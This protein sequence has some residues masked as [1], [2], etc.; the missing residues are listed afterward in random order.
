LKKHLATEFDINVFWHEGFQ[1]K[2][3]QFSNKIHSE[4]LR[5]W[6]ESM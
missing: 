5:V 2:N 4:S 1:L 3:I 6:D